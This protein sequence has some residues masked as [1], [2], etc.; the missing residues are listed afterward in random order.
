MIELET[1]EKIRAFNRLYTQAIG[2][3]DDEHEGLAVTLGESRMLFAV[4]SFEL[5]SVNQ[6]AEALRL[7]LA[8]ASRLLGALE[9]RQLVKRTISPV[10]RR[11]RVVALTPK[12]S[13]L[14]ETIEKRSNQRVMTLVD[15]LSAVDLRR[16]L[17]AMDT[18]AGLIN[19]K[20]PDVLP[21]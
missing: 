12:G 6:I 2:S 20:E 17:E 13:R 9:D 5:P 14:L 18:I 19:E 21:D 15:H 10:D 7:D 4:R 8:Y 1:A 16:L 3:L 11:R